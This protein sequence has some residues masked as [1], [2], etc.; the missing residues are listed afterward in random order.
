MVSQVAEN[1][2]L[3]RV[4]EELFSS[5]GYEIYLKP[6]SDYV[7][8]GRHDVRRGDRSGATSQR[9]RDRLPPRAAR[10]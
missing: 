8:N 4:F 6:A 1:P 9:D 5:E 3:V 7:K 2:H 10:E